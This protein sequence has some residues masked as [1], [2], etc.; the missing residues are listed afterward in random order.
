MHAGGDELPARF[1]GVAS[2]RDKDNDHYKRTLRTLQIELVKLQRDLIESEARVLVILEGRDGAGKDGTIKH[3][4]EHMSPRETRIF[5]PPKPSDREL[6]ELYFQRFVVLT[7]GS[8]IVH[9]L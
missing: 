6:R 9:H 4:I 7:L 2:M 5:A 1:F 8:T 3:L